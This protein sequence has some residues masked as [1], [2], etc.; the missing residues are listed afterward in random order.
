M[1]IPRSLLAVLGSLQRLSGLDEGFDKMGSF[2][3]LAGAERLAG[4]R[5]ASASIF[6]V[7]LSVE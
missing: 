6:F 7:A 3:G 2:V 5:F 4:L 1:E